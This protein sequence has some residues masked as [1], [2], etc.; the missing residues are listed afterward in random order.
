MF[1]KKDDKYH[2]TLEL[3]EHLIEKHKSDLKH[4][5]RLRDC[6]DVA[7]CD[8]TIMR[9]IEYHRGQITVL[10]GLLDKIVTSIGA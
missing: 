3:I 6:I 8:A 4:Y 1:R 2:K 9:E 5:C 7:R 10:E